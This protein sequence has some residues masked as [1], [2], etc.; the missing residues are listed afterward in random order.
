M[1]QPIR[2]Q[3]SLTDTTEVSAESNRR[4]RLCKALRPSS[5]A[6]Q[7]MHSTGLTPILAPDKQRG[8]ALAANRNVHTAIPEGADNLHI[9]RQV[10]SLANFRK[11]LRIVRFGTS[12]T[13]IDETSKNA[14][15]RVKF[16]Q[17]RVVVK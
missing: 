15:W 8:I 1:H 16:P 5:C 10:N 3:T 12:R 17:V 11:K 4:L 9:G 14:A 2:F 13:A 7:A 6:R